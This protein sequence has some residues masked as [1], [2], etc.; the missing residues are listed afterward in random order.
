MVDALVVGSGPNGLAAAITLAREGRSVRVLEAQPTIGG[1]ARSAELTLPGF[2][3]DRCSAIY[4]LAI[5]SPFFSSLSLTRHG[6][7]WIQPELA[8]A[9]PLDDGSAAILSQSLED[10][11]TSLGEDGRAYRQLM[12]PL[13]R[14]WEMLVD[15]F[16]QPIVH[17][18]RHPWLLARFGLSAVQS[19]ATLAQRQFRGDRAQALFAGLAAHSFLPLEEA[20]SA[21]FGLVLAIM[22]HAV[23]WPLPRGGSQ[24]IS[25]ALAAQLR[26]LGGLIETGH[27]VQDVQKLESARAVLL[28][29]TSW[30]TSR[31]ARSRL[32]TAYRE[33]LERFPHGPSV[34]KMD[35]ALNGPI[36]WKIDACRRAG[37]IHLGGTLIEIAAS[38]REVARGE[39]P[40]RPFVLLAQQSVFDQTRTP[41]GKHTAWAYCHVP[42]GCRADVSAAIETQIERFAPGF[43]SLI[44]ARC[45]S[46]PSA[47]ES[48]NANL[49]GG[50]IS[51]GANDLRHLFARPILSAVPYRTPARGLYLCSSSTPPGGGVHGMCGYHAARAAL[52]REL[53]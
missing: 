19:A 25:D 29:L 7:D 53:R 23:G 33:R 44:L 13:L 10:T 31:V 34:F 4:P 14:K 17:L 5:C 37:T 21:S 51:G 48:H 38:E 1:G 36:P 12:E 18:P 41:A 40:S 8:L 11:C 6:L 26:E 2:V 27:P 16:L 47:L 35:Y 42:R 15:E 43:S 22:G 20:G 3:H 46:N 9:H 28:D 24:K 32:P 49:D 50:D 30:R 52:A 39:I 45:V